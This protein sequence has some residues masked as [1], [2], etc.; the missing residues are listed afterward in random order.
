MTF[1]EVG[2]AT[3][4]HRADVSRALRLT[5]EPTDRTKRR[6]CSFFDISEYAGLRRDELRTASLYELA[7]YGRR[8][9]EVAERL[10]EPK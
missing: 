2:R 3:R 6:L 8:I 7:Y 1:A 10:A 9:A 5:E 4:V